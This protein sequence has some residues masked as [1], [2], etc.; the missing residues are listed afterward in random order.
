MKT[1]SLCNLKGG[2]GKTVTTVHLGASLAALGHRVLL[3]DVDLQNGLTKYFDIGDIEYSTS[4]VLLG[5]CAIG[6][7][8]RQVRERLSVIPST[9]E[10]ERAEYELTTAPAGEL[11]LR[12]VL[13]HL[14]TQDEYD[15][16]FLD[17]PSGWGTVTRNALLS[18]DAL[19]VPINSEQAARDC[20]HDTIEGARLLCDLHEAPTPQISVLLTRLRAS[21][22]ARAVVSQTVAD[23]GDAVYTTRIRQAEKINELAIRRAALGDV[24]SAEMGGVGEDYRALAKEVLAQSKPISSTRK[25][26]TKKVQRG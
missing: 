17:C 24:S 8:T 25:P 5:D 11:R 19:I 23:W 7:A 20:A 16:V 22:A 1:I 3:I 2:V 26:A 21:N 12:R 14:A 10:M 18:S 9:K 15:F 6:D 13:R 4:D